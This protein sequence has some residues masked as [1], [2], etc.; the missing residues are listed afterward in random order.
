MAFVTRPGRGRGGR[1]PITTPPAA[2]IHASTGLATHVVAPAG[3]PRWEA[4]RG[5]S[6]WKIAETTLGDGERS[7]EILEHNPWLGAARHLQPGHVRTLPA[8]ATVPVDRQPAPPDTASAESEPDGYAEA[9]HIVIEAGDTLWDLAEERLALVDDDVTEAE[10]LT[11]VHEVIAANPDV[12][13]D[14]NLIYPGEVFAFPAVGTPPPPEADPTPTAD[15]D[16]ATPDVDEI[17]TPPESR[18]DTTPPPAD[19]VPEPA[20]DTSSAPAIPA[21][22]RPP[23]TATNSN[24]SPPP[25]SAAPTIEPAT[26]NRPAAD[27]TTVPWLPGITGATVLASGVLLLYRRRV[28]A[29]ATRD[30]TAY[31]CAPS[32]PTALTAITRAADVSLLRWAA[33]ELDRLTRQL[34]PTGVDGQPLAI[35]LSDTYGIELLWTAPNPAA[36]APWQ[37]TDDGWAWA[38]PYDPDAPVDNTDHPTAIPA[39]V[40]IGTRDSNQLLLNLEAVG[41]LAIDAD[42]EPAAG[43]LRSIVAE[44]AVGG[45]VSDAYLVTSGLDLAG[46]DHLDRIQ[47]YPRDDARAHLAAAADASRTYLADHDLA[48][49]FATRLG[50]DATGRETT[51]VAVDDEY[52]EPLTP[53]I[54]AGLAAAHLYTGAPTSGPRI[55]IAADGHAVLEPYGIEFQPAS[56]PLP[57]VHTVAALLD[58]P[59]EPDTTTGTDE[60]APDLD[61]V[62]EPDTATADLGGDEDDDWHHP[63]PEILVRVLGAPEVLDVDGLGPIETSIITYLACHGGTRRDEQVINAVWNGRALEHKTLWNKISKIRSRLGQDLV[64]QRMPNSP[65]VVLSERVTTDLAVLTALHERAGHVSESEAVELLLR[66][67]DLIDGVPFDSA[68]YD[69]AHETQ[70]HA[71]ACEAVQVA[72]LR[73]VEIAM[74]LGDL[75]AARHAVTQGLRALPMNEPLYRARMRIESAGGNPDGVRQ[76]LGELTTALDIALDGDGDLTPEPETLRLAHE[77][78]K[79]S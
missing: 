11:H 76:A 23:A 2:V 58:N 6:L 64:P 7:V 16:P 57:T 44:L 46:L 21:A 72:T 42:D 61:T 43:L 10:T 17:A 37:A 26:T 18:V 68:E 55:R 8:D 49:A 4:A 77:L 59:T 25:T 45:I 40:T 41:T 53:G 75:V 71:A 54:A 31:R 67:L 38:L 66:G 79:A 15:T 5:D 47:T 12:V 22:S 73:C 36:P 60:P 32:N 14:P 70:D 63:D 3:A 20:V 48:T 19:P 9:T 39:L 52:A 50:G 13:E 74:N 56:L 62:V 65:N 27:S 51:I 33:S 78:T 35:E 30:A 29:R 69:W 24:P 34:D 28:A 1:I